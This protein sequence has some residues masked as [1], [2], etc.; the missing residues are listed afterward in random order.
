MECPRCGQ[1]DVQ[2]PACPRC[3]VVFVK[4]RPARVRAP[5]PE[6]SSPAPTEAQSRRPR[7]LILG[8]YAL[9]LTVALGAWLLTRP[10]ASA[11]TV[12][13]PAGPVRHSSTSHTRTNTPDN[14]PLLHFH[15]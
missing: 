6:P 10:A 8:I 12:A 7:T 4:L 13:G 9:A 2:A 3:G 5:A 1:T 14:L 15:S 11:G